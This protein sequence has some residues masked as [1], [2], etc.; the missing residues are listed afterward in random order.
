MFETRRLKGSIL[1]T[2]LLNT[3]EFNKTGEG[4]SCCYSCCFILCKPTRALGVNL[5]LLLNKPAH[6]PPEWEIKTIP[7]WSASKEANFIHKKLMGFF[8]LGIKIVASLFYGC[9]VLC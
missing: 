6:R 2:D 3:H 1:S 7:L 9:L 4:I 8:F 5:L